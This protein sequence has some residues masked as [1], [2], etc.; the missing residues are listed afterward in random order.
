[1]VQ[2]GEIVGAHG[3]RGEVRVRSL[4]AEP[5]AVAAYGPLHD[6]AGRRMLRL[7][8]RGTSGGVVICAIEGVADRNGAEALKGVRLHVPRSR[9]PRTAED[10][11]YPADL[12]GLAAETADGKPAGRVIGVHNFGAGDL[13]VVA[14][15]DGERWVPFT[16]RAVPTVD[17]AAGRIVIDPPV[18]T[19]GEDAE[20]GGAAP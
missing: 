4:T 15:E 12:I 1:M 9:L 11:F 17:L 3:I 14:G 10:E 6:L 7:R 13:I 5:R 16:R 20:D 8:A 18:E 2:I 19:G